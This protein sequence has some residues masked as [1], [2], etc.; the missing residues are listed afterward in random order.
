MIIQGKFLN[1]KSLDQNVL[2]YLRVSVRSHIAFQ[3]N[4]ANLKSETFY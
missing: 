1:L 3:K 2:T 4:G